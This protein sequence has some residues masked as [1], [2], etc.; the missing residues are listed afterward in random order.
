M[1][2]T[3]SKAQWQQIT[4]DLQRV[5][6]HVQFQYQGVTVAIVR[7]HIS[8]SRSHLVV[9]F[10]NKLC[11]G[12]GWKDSEQ[13]NPMANVFWCQRKRRLYSPKRVAEVEKR[14]GKRKAKEYFPD[15][16]NSFCYLVPYFS[17]SSTLVRQFKKVPS[18]TFVNQEDANHG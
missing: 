1:S 4:D 14:M 9:Y 5:F 7:E 18:L 13:F 11:P 10:D 2:E 15:L 17:S 6:C 16:H 8:E 3:I 12:W